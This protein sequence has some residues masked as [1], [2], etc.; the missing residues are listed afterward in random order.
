M[1]VALYASFT[2][3]P[4]PQVSAPGVR[5]GAMLGEA[6]AT[7]MLLSIWASG[8][9]VLGLC[10]MLTRGKTIIREVEL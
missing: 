2:P 6:I 10:A 4:D 5:S 9:V 3:L 7:T 8:A 1:A